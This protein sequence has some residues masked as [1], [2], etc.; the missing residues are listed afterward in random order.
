MDFSHVVKQSEGPDNAEVIFLSGVPS[1]DC[2]PLSGA[3]RAYLFDAC[4]RAGISGP[5]IRL[6]CVLGEIPPGRNPYALGHDRTEQWQKSCL[7]RLKRLPARILVPLDSLALQ[8]VTDH[9]SLDDWHLSIVPATK[10]DGRKVIPIFSPDRLFAVYSDAP[11]FIYGLDRIKEQLAFPEIRQK[12]RVYHTGSSYPEVM[13]YLHRC[14]SAQALS[15]DIE[16]SR[17]QITCVGI[18]LSPTEAMSIRVSP[19]DWDTP[20]FWEIWSAIAA[21]LGSQIPKIF[22]NYIYDCTY[23]SKYGIVVRGLWHDTMHANKFLHPELKC[24][25]DTVA[26]LYTREPYW[27][28]EGKD[29]KNPTP[30]GSDPHK[31]WIYN[32]KDCAV[33]YEAALGQ[34]A[35]LVS[36]GLAD[37]FYNFVMPLARPVS[38]MCWRGLPVDLPKREVITRDLT[39]KVENLNVQLGELAVPVLG[40]AINARSPKQLKEFFRAKKFKIPTKKGQESTDVTSLL[41]MQLKHPTDPVFPVLLQLSE[42][43]KALSSYLKPAPYPDGRHRYSL[44]LTGTDTLRFSCR[45]DP[46]DNGLNAQTIPGDF[47]P[48]FVAPP[49]WLFAE[50][51]LKQADARVVAWAA[52]EPTLISFFQSGRDIHRFVASQP[53]LFNKPESEITDLERQLGK[54]SGHAGNYG[55]RGNTYSESCLREMNLIISPQRSQDMID[56]YYRTFPGIPMWHKRIQQEIRST[57]KLTTPT[58]WERYFY[59]RLGDDL[60]RQAYAFV[61]QHTVAWVINRLMTHMC[62]ERH[63]EKLHLLVQV[64]DSLVMLIRE[65]YLTEAVGLI[66]AEHAWN[67]KMSLAGGILQIPVGLKVGPTWKDMKEIHAP[68]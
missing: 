56:S 52:P 57:K 9:K 66:F 2:T 23:F 22:Q 50:C 29:W 59:D 51:D 31:F 30:V 34:Q 24:G 39:A 61:P 27:K 10:L 13:S 15:V 44:D 42:F 6:E 16:T 26:R 45:K 63:P 17:G 64:H 67:P 62:K 60:F 41:K 46:W 32:C 54:K 1:W 11:Y 33:T 38:E 14:K 55:V 35:D 5:S 58:G 3:A 53:G 18:A 12:A 49:G 25:L 48:M 47:K 37:R 40:K 43:N 7:E 36:R 28:G 8:T 65:D 20:T 21:L 68:A 4:R 19:Q